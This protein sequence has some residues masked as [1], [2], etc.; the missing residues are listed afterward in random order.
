[1]HYRVELSTEAQKQLARFPRDAR[2]RLERAIDE[3]DQKDDSEWSNIKAL[4]GNKW[5]GRLRKRV[6]PYRLIFRKYPERGVLEISAVL[7]KSND[8]YR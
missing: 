7:I 1:M 2:E 3:L 8:T 6:G 5:K 4:Q